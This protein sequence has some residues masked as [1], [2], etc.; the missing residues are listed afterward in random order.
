[1][2]G[3]TAKNPVYIIYICIIYINTNTEIVSLDVG[4][5][6]EEYFENNSVGLY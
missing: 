6:R 4:V 3:W 5:E 2:D 1:M